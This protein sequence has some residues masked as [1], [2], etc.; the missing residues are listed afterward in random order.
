MSNRLPKLGAMHSAVQHLDSRNDWSA[1]AV[2]GYIPSNKLKATA[3]S[4][5]GRRKNA[6]LQTSFELYHRPTVIHR[7]V[8]RKKGVGAGAS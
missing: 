8:N 6:F 3:K 4:T 7:N 2:A 5:R 1:H